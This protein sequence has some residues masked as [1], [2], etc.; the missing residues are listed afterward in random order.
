METWRWLVINSPDTVPALNQEA[1]RKYEQ[2]NPVFF[3]IETMIK[4][5][6]QQST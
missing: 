6:Q 1:A 5:F 4:N 3:E 2:M